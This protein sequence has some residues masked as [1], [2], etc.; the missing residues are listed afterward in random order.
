MDL[1]GRANEIE[2]LD[3]DGLDE[4]T[5]VEAYD[6]MA[7]VNKFFGGRAVVKEFIEGECRRL[8]TDRL[9]IL[10]VGSGA[11]DIPIAMRQWSLK[12][13]LDLQF[14]CLEISDFA[15]RMGQKNIQKSGQSGI[16]IL[17]ADV[18]DYRSGR[19]FDAAIGSMFFHHFKADEIVRIGEIVREAGCRSMLI[20]DLSRSWLNYYA[21]VAISFVLSKAVRHDALM[22]IRRGFRA[23]DLYEILGRLGNAQIEV[24][25]RWFCRVAGIVRWE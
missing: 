17:K 9:S 4:S 18:F 13:G 21:C 2:L 5:L 20:N 10:D 15:Y 8:N 6:F 1:S 22:S 7:S 23:E 25:R 12:N 11:C 14:T 19:K 16:E 3:T 24:R